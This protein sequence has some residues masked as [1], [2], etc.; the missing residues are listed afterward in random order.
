[1]PAGACSGVAASAVPSVGPRCGRGT[2]NWAQAGQGDRQ[3]HECGRE[4]LRNRADHW[5]SKYLEGAVGR[6]VGSR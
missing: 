5:Y 1:M 6:S 3:Q 2:A 4:P